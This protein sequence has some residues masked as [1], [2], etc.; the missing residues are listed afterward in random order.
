[1]THTHLSRFSPKTFL[2]KVGNGKI[3]LNPEKLGVLFSQGDSANAV[4]YIQKGRVKLTAVSPQGK[5]AV[6]GILEQGAFFGEGCLAG[7][8]VCV[9]TATALDASVVVRID[10]AAMM[11]V[12][13]EEPTFAALFMAYLLSHSIRVQEDLVDHLFNSAEKRLARILLLMAHF[14]KEGQPSLVIPKISQ[15]MLA[16]MVGTTRSRVSFFMK[17][18]KQLGFIKYNAGLHVHSS[19]LNV[20]LCD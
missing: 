1:M 5:E 12:L 16:G 13:H 17:R 18:F 3:S 9:A 8:L 2:A 19:L 4:F 14:G 15:E 6:I 20:V 11:R 7:Q 10:K